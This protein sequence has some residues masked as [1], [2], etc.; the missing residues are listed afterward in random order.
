MRATVRVGGG[1]PQ[2]SANM[3]EAVEALPGSAVD[4]IP[5]AVRH[6]RVAG[7]PMVKVVSVEIGVHPGPVLQQDF[8]IL[9]AR[10]RGQIKQL[11]DVER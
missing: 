7:H 6:H 11:E 3:I 2:H 1:A 5:I 8:V 10:Q 4:L 9:G